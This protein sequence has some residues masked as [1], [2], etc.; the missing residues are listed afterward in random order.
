[1]QV[2][3]VQHSRRRAG[4]AGTREREWTARAEIR[5]QQL[6]YKKKEKAAINV[7]KGKTDV[8]T[9]LGGYLGLLGKLMVEGGGSENERSKSQADIQW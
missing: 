9:L 6:T 5:R 1:M 3:T 4:D 7:A 8:W 2:H